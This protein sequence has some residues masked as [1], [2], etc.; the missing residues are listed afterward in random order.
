MSETTKTHRAE[1]AAASARSW[2][3]LANDLIDLRLRERAKG[4][5]AQADKVSASVR[6]ARSQSVRA[7]ARRIL[8]EHS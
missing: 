6:F 2:N 4:H 3:N 8:A 1:A 5:W 7:R